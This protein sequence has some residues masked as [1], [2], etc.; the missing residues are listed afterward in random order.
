[1]SKK[2][3]RRTV[4]LRGIQ[5]PIGGFLAFGLGACG[6]NDQA[7]QAAGNVCADLDAMTDG[8][9]SSRRSLNYQE[10]SPKPNEVCADCAFFHAA[11]MC[12]TC[13]MFN[14]GPVNPKGRC[15]SW[16]AKA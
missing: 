12:G 3:S 14:G 5:V 15:D 11:G 16:S 13:D 6:G 1:L 8:E 4:L 10:T 7:G 9:R 2:I